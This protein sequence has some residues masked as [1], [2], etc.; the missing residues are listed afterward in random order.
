MQFKMLSAEWQPF[1]SDLNM[2]NFVDDEFYCSVA[3]L[4]A[5]I[6]SGNCFHCVRT[7][8]KYSVHHC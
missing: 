1:C 3:S 7:Q 5:E 6:F 4:Y 2:L 8:V